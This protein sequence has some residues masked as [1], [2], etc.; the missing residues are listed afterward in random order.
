MLKIYKRLF[1]LLLFGC[2]LALTACGSSGSS[3]S[4]STD[5]T[6]AATE[7]L[8]LPDQLEVVTDET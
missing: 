7:T 4:D 5:S 3:S 1:L 8:V 6:N 2:S